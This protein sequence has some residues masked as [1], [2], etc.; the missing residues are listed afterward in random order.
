MLAWLTVITGGIVAIATVALAIITRRYVIITNQ[1]LKASYKPEVVAFL[2][3]RS[4]YP[5]E[6]YEVNE[7][8]ICIKNVGPGTA[9]NISFGDDLSFKPYGG[10]PLE[11]IGFL[12]YGIDCLAPGEERRQSQPYMQ[13]RFGDLNQ[14]KVT[15][16][17]SYKDPHGTIYTEPFPLNFEESDLPPF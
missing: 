4:K 17:I 6:N 5:P 14:I 10:D 9:R 3:K 7:I 16:N 12:K 8:A 1:I 13:N 15:I 11:S 2:R